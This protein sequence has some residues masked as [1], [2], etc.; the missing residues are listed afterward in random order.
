MRTSR[1]CFEGCVEVQFEAGIL[2]QSIMR[3]FKNVHFVVTFKVNEACSGVVQSVVRDYEPA[4]V[5]AHHLVVWTSV[6]PETH[7]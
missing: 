4:I 7:Y 3:D 1:P 2:F 6:V 5:L